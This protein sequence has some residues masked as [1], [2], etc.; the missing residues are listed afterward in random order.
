MEIDELRH[1]VCEYTLIV[2]HVLLQHAT[3]H[4]NTH[5]FSLSPGD[6]LLAVDVGVTGRF[7]HDGIRYLL[8]QIA[9]APRG[10]S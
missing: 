1:H 10:V 4:V 6:E 9:C 3:T 2:L 8:E 7:F 5:V